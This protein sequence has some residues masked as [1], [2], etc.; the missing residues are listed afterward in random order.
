[1]PHYH[2][3]AVLS[4][5]AAKGHTPL[6]RARQNLQHGGMPPSRRTLMGPST[7]SPG[8]PGGRRW[9]TEKGKA[10]LEGMGYQA[11]GD[12]R[13]ALHL[14]RRA[15]AAWQANTHKP[16]QRGTTT[17]RET[18]AQRLRNDINERPAEVK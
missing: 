2:P 18:T 13:A 9:G 8:G 15:C 6:L 11:V 7:S 16:S 4:T 5:S 1:M 17:R 14:R 10:G 12:N 3:Y